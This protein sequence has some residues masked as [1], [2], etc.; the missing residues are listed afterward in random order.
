[1]AQTGSSSGESD[2]SSELSDDA[3]F[4]EKASNAAEVK[5][6]DVLRSAAVLVGG[7]TAST[8]AFVNV[9]SQPVK[10]EACADGVPT[11]NDQIADVPG[12][13]ID[14]IRLNGDTEFRFEWDNLVRGDV[15]PLQLLCRPLYNT[16]V[17]DYTGDWEVLSRMGV[18]VTKSSGVKFISGSQFFEERSDGK[19][20][21]DHSQIS[22][23]DVNVDTTS[24]SPD[25]DVS[26][27]D[28]WQTIKSELSTQLQS[29][30]DSLMCSDM[31]VVDLVEKYDDY[32]RVSV[33]ELKLRGNM[34]SRDPNKRGIHDIDSWKLF[35]I[36]NAPSGWGLSFGKSFASPSG[37]LL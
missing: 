19:S 13:E 23:S 31:G 27:N 29:M 8:V 35:V 14:D 3:D 12:G 2:E 36:V 6:R 5:R 25:I 1:M 33:F 10:A 9:G 32:L 18:Q 11:S 22:L 24:S 21:T 37:K 26:E 30:S 4:V 16:G 28:T 15:V 20:L 34:P 7:T 17:T